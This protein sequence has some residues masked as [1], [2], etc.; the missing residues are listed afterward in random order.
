ME[1]S[2][3]VAKISTLTQENKEQNKRLDKL[4]DKAESIPRLEVLMQ[5]VVDTNEKQSNT[6]DMINQN[7]TGLNGEMKN[8]SSQ[9][10][11]L[12]GRVEKLE[13]T[14][15][16]KKEFL[17]KLV[18]QTIFVVVPGLVLAALALYFGLK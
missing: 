11:T 6:L 13:E 16:E 18:K 2:E 3:I 15:T 1:N 14:E 8:L 5:M 4:E 7:L 9:V 17:P 12:G 10:S